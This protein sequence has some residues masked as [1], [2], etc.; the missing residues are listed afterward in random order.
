MK[1]L[2]RYSIGILILLS[3]SRS[4]AIESAFLEL[5]GNSTKLEIIKKLERFKDVKIESTDKP[6]KIISINF[7]APRDFKV[8][9]KDLFEKIETSASGDVLDHKLI[10]SDPKTGKI[11]HLN[12]E[13]KLTHIDLISPWSS[14]GK[15]QTFKE[16]LGELNQNRYKDFK[17]IKKGVK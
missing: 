7:E 3:V 11:F 4:W 10:L 2:N 12:N 1:N 15:L 8:S 5:N 14:K 9:E 17:K 6:E 16:I 13:L